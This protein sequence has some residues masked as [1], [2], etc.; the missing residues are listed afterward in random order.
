MI[1][2][3]D[4]KCQSVARCHDSQQSL[5]RAGVVSPKASLI[6]Y[7]QLS[8][9][10]CSMNTYRRVCC[11][12]ML[13]ISNKYRNWKLCPLP[14]RVFTIIIY[15][16]QGL[17]QSNVEMRFHELSVWFDI[18]YNIWERDAGRRRRSEEEGR[19]KDVNTIE[20]NIW[21]LCGRSSVSPLQTFWRSLVIE[22]QT[23]L[24]CRNFIHN[25]SCAQ[26]PEI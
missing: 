17:D 12:I 15:F 4:W 8:S 11:K 13:E 3:P 20:G 21:G 18:Q 25:S 7:S 2:A 19:W 14:F 5:A 6:R 23:K 22:N 10:V 26:W 24:H 1:N 16:H 9:V